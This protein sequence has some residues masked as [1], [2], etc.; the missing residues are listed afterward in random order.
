[1]KVALHVVTVVAGLAL[2][3]LGALVQAQGAGQ[4]APA[5][6][7]TPA[8]IELGEGTKARYKVA[9]RLVGV[10]F[11]TDAVGTTEAVT[12]TVVVRADG[13]IDSSA[14]KITVDLRTLKSDQA[15]RDMFLQGNVLQTAKFPMLEFVPQ[16]AV[17]M[18]FP[19][20]LGTKLQGTNITMPQ[21]AG[22]Q[23][24]GNM[25]VHG[26]TKEV[27]WNI[28]STINAET[29]SGRATTSILFSTFGITKPAVPLLASVEDKIEL[30]VEFR[31]KRSAM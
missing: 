18:P 25:T 4:A 5:A 23:L 27:T 15:L 2:Y 22:F 21:A 28:V 12:G 8:K 1:M 14:S 11:G 29:V 6:P 9:E 10:N 26:V 30:E 20:P 3:G 16:R 13:S 19:L 17:G 7:P 31:G 24:V